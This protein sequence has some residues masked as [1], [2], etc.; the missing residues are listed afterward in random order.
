MREYSQRAVH[1]QTDIISYWL[2]VLEWTYSVLSYVG[3][4]TLRKKYALYSAA[5]IVSRILELEK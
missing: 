2:A 5:I 4:P 3:F 1:S